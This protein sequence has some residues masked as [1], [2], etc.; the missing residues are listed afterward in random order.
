[1]KILEV[2]DKE[3]DCPWEGQEEEISMKEIILEKLE[4]KESQETKVHEDLKNVKTKHGDENR[5]KGHGNEKVIQV[6]VVI[7]PLEDVRKQSILVKMGEKDF[8][9]VLKVNHG[10]VKCQEE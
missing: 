10:V 6:E 1:M 4:K 2:E 5:D 9:E 3:E 8:E 7:C